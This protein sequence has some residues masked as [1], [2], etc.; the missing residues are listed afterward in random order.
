MLFWVADMEM[1]RVLIRWLSFS[2]T[3]CVPVALMPLS[4]CV[5]NAHNIGFSY[6]MNSSKL[7]ACHLT[8]NGYVAD[9]LERPSLD[10]VRRRI[11]GESA[12]LPSALQS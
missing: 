5:S 6:V 8:A 4:K 9:K 12:I 11:F 1:A 10:H 3:Y 7:L 2:N